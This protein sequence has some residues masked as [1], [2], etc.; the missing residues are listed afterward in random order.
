M[1]TQLLLSAIA[2]L[3]ATSCSTGPQQAQPGT[4]AFIWNAAKAT[5]HSGDFVKTSE[6]LQ[7]LIKLDNEFTAKAR[8]WSIV[9][10]AGLAQGYAAT[11]DAYEAGARANRANP[12]PFRKEVN[13]L[14]SMATSAATEFAEELHNYMDKEKAPSVMLAF[15]GPNGS[16]SEPPSFRKVYAG[17]WIQD[18]ERES[19][20]KAM[21][22]RG[23]VL[24]A[25][26][27]AGSPDDSA[28][29]AEVLKTGE[30]QR[31]RVDFLLG[32]AKELYERSDLFTATKLDHPG[33]MR[34]LC[35]EA[36]EAVQAGPET[37]ESK[38]LGAKI[39]AALKKV[40]AAS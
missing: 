2:L 21:L 35:T 29:G 37:K 39:E 15:D 38:A 34:L 1:R 20:L 9:V 33:R 19:L 3:A 12:T 6:N 24:S 22:Q 23:V 31:P 36:M 11:A 18:S 40:K 25:S 16:A 14:R 5:W 30:A 27:A 26:R 28:K 4:P 7:Q 13:Q 8:P 17:A 10:A 32:F